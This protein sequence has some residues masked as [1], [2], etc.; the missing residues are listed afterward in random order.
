MRRDRN[1]PTGEGRVEAHDRVAALSQPHLPLRP[2]HACVARRADLPDESQLLE[3]RLELGSGDPPLDA[4]RRRKRRLNRRSLAVAAEV[5]A[6]PRSQVARAADVEHLVLAAEE[7]V[8]ARTPRRAEGEM[9]LV[10]QAS[11]PRRRESREVGD[12]SRAAFLREADQRE[13]QLGGRACVG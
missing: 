13:Q 4:L 6:Q 11:S 2:R 1:G 3:R 5:R 9:A 8:D 7:E 10:E 12:G